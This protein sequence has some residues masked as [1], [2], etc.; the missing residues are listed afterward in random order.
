[1][2]RSKIPKPSSD[3]RGEVG[4][5]VVGHGQD[6]LGLDHIGSQHDPH[7]R[8]I[9]GHQETLEGHNIHMLQNEG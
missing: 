1:M 9:G 2:L 5:E 4:E 8:I 6:F 3:G 7:L